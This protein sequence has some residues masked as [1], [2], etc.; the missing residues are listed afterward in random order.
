LIPLNDLKRA[1][2]EDSPR[3]ESAINRVVKSG[4]FILG[5]ELEAFENEFSLYQGGGYT[6]GVG[7]GTDALEISLVALGIKSGDLVATTA[8][9]GGYATTAIK[10][11]GAIPLYIDVDYQTALM[12]KTS[13]EK[14]LTDFPN[15]KCII[16]THLYGNAANVI[17]IQQIAR[18]K[19]IL[20]LEDCAQAIGAEISAIKVGNFGDAATF[21]F[22][23]TKNLG[24]IG[25]AGCVF[26]KDLNLALNMKKLRQYGWNSK[27]HSEIPA[28]QNSRM[29][30]VQAAVLRFRLEFIDQQNNKRRQILEMY[31]DSIKKL[32][33][34]SLWFNDKR[35]VGHLAVLSLNYRL[36][37]QQ[38]LNKNEIKSEI[39][40]PVLDYQQLAWADSSQNLKNSEQLVQRILTI[41]CFP[42]LTESEI[43]KISKTISKFSN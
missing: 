9:C 7:N 27:Y 37:A 28:G 10:K 11:I 3:I 13:L 12:S 40:Y 23:P 31:Q 43:N 38:L 19:K 35:S 33:E 39:H 6:V 25:D 17:D 4:W 21:S 8:N 36:D 26:T 32:G 1:A 14:N 41:P 34:V 22:F 30:E 29:D 42:Q 18:R 16:V 20:L 15:I 2:E 24:A 5:P